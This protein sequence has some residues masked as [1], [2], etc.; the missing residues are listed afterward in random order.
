M[1]GKF[2]YMQFAIM[3]FASSSAYG[4][5]GYFLQDTTT[6]KNI[7][8]SEVEISRRFNPVKIVPG[9]LSYQVSKNTVGSSGN[10]LELLRKMP[11]VTILPNGKI[12]L[13]G[14]AG[15]QLLIDGKTNF[16]DGENLINFLSS[17]PASYLD[18]VEL[19]TQP[20]AGMDA[21]GDARFI[22][23]KRAIRSSNGINV[24]LSTNAEQGIYNRN[25]H[26][27]TVA[28]NMH[29][30]NISNTYS[31]ANGID[32]INVNSA[33]YL[34]NAINTGNNTLRLDMDAIRKKKYSNHYYN[35]TLDYRPNDKIK[36]GTYLLLSDQERTKEETVGSAFFYSRPL[37]DST[38]ATSNGLRHH[39]KNFST[40]VHFIV[41]FRA[42]SKWENYL[43]R[44]QVKQTE[45]QH[46]LLDKFI[47]DGAP[48]SLEQQLRG[49]TGGKVDI[50]TMQS[51]YMLEIQPNIAVSFGGKFTQVGMRTNSFYQEANNKNWQKRPDLINAFDHEERLKALF[52]QAR[53]NPSDL[54]QVD[55]GL[56][57]EDAAFNS[58][59]ANGQGIDLTIV[60]A[61]RNFFPNLTMTYALENKQ[62]LSVNYHRRVNRPNFKDLSPFIEVNDPYLYE[63]GN[64]ALKPEF[65][66]NME[67]TWLFKDFYSLQLFYSLRQDAISKS[68]N[69]D[70][71]KRTVVMPMNLKHASS[72][73]LRVNATSISPTQN[74]NIQVNGNLIYKYFE[75]VTANDVHRNRQLTPA[76]QVQSNIKLPFKVN[77]DV[78]C[79]WNGATADGQATMASLWS[80]NSG[81]RKTF[82]QDK[83]T[84]Y[85]YANDLFKTNRPKIIFNSDFMEG[86]YR[87]S[88]DSRAV[89][90]NLSYRL[91]RG[92]KSNLKSDHANDRLE[93]N[94]RINY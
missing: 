43:D 94:S 20:D 44:Q 88:Y 12:S 45:T 18:I 32:L 9:K 85:I 69:L 5:I 33:R 39:F 51:K 70:D 4:E 57:Y 63:K 59:T 79:F 77:L 93:E 80:A 3:L 53:Y 50:T 6:D 61:Y 13:N 86:K 15:V 73:G 37:A 90:I 52:M 78:N 28:A 2:I 42:G 38:I 67:F 36:M 54:L 48:G 65:V 87:E 91:H 30:L 23:L 29:K 19:I 46:Q 75:W 84:L 40:G 74:W 35:G 68:Y 8:L 82:L 7:K 47:E 66:N 24:L 10:V 41:Q 26:T 1:S 31:Y 14:Q 22:N 49:E 56:R 60:R 72:I 21:N 58:S 76:L 25:Y 16:I 81:L 71:Y 92:K 17:M 62:K 27:I 55:L 83:F 11:G 34:S 64:P 89:G